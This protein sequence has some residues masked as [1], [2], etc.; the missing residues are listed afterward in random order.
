MTFAVRN[1]SRRAETKELKEEHARYNKPQ[2]Q[3]LTMQA[4]ASSLPPTSLSSGSVPCFMS[5][6]DL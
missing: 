6:G 2:Q 4:C 3:Q 5:R 1:E